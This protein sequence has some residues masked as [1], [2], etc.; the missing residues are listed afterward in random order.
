ML[1]LLKTFAKHSD[2]YQ[3]E[4]L[5]EFLYA[6]SIGRLRLFKDHYP[7]LID[8]LENIEHEHVKILCKII[9]EVY[10]KSL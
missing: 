7:L 6:L 10:E 8:E 3:G 2:E 9:L 1:M 4:A 5:M